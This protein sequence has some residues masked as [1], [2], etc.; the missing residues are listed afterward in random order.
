MGAG[1]NNYSPWTHCLDHLPVV[2]QTRL[3]A[4]LVLEWCSPRDASGNEPPRNVVVDL[5][6][7]F[8]VPEMES[9]S[10][11]REVM[12]SLLEEMPEG[13]QRVVDSHV[14]RDRPVPDDMDEMNEAAA[15][16]NGTNPFYLGLKILSWGPGPGNYHLRPG[17][18]VSLEHF[19]DPEVKKAYLVLKGLIKFL[20]INA[21]SYMLKK[22]LLGSSAFTPGREFADILVRNVMTTPEFWSK[23]RRYVNIRDI[24]DDSVPLSEFGQNRIQG[25]AS[26]S[27]RDQTE[28]N[29][30]L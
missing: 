2:C 6:T 25:F 27:R 29:G 18:T 10:I 24:T 20:R 15:S 19:S 22:V 8:P 3:G 9:L 21:S 16:S 28:G 30:H 26:S 1:Q 4:C 17:Q 13:W 12:K 5:I 23:F 7:G 14:S 11:F